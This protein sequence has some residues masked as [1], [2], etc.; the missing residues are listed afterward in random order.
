MQQAVAAW[1]RA[2][3]AVHVYLGLAAALFVLFY[4]LLSGHQVP[5]TWIVRLKWL[6]TWIF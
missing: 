3:H 5:E 1:P 4:P 2:R 6:K